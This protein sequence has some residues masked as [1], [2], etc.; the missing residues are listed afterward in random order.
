M[1]EMNA[2]E[3]AQLAGVVTPDT[4]E[5]PGAKFLVGI[6][7]DFLDCTK[8]GEVLTEDDVTELADSAVPVYTWPMWKTFVDLGAWQEDLESGDP[9]MTRQA[10]VAL[11]QIA[12][13]LYGILV[14][15]AITVE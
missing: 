11:F 13:R 6:Y 5:S 10:M 2:Y 12:E 9:D 15:E 8:D 3:L 1:G 7:E 14:D 4:L